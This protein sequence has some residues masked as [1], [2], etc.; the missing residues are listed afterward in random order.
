MTREKYPRE[1]LADLFAIDIRSLALFRIVLSSVILLDLALRVPLFD[2]LTTAQGVL[3]RPPF[4]PSLYWFSPQFVAEEVFFALG[5]A[6]T[7]SLLVGFKTRFFGILSW[8]SLLSL[9][10][11]NPRIVDSAD[12]V[13]IQLHFWGLL[14]PWGECFSVDAHIKGSRKIDPAVKCPA[15]VLSIAS[16]GLLLQPAFVYFFSVFHKIKGAAWR[17]GTAVLDALTYETRSRPFGLWIADHDWVGRP[18]T[19]VTLL[20]ELVAPLLLF[21][22]WRTG[23]TRLVGI[24]CLLVFQLALS[25]SLRLGLFPLVMSIALVPF[26][27]EK[28][29][30]QPWVHAWPLQAC[31]RQLSEGVRQT[32][33]VP[34][35]FG[36][37]LLSAVLLSNVDHLTS[38]ITLAPL[39]QTPLTW[40]RLNQNWKMFAPFPPRKNEIVRA[41][42]RLSDGT[43][44]TLDGEGPDRFEPLAKIRNGYRGEIYFERLGRWMEASEREDFAAWLVKQWVAHDAPGRTVSNVELSRFEWSRDAPERREETVLL[45]WRPPVNQ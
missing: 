10:V 13:L 30:N 18:L 37:T 25:L 45:N 42:L 31:S 16:A 19:Y 35:F 24:L 34:Q 4:V 41:T 28:F 14:L 8:V 23:R 2:E 6:C 12:S 20:I 43:T 11:R 7:L 26:V 5:A 27:P 29:W 15:K 3:S 17:D 9:Q 36:V 21:S 38:R 22:T 39:V 40:L 33:L 44:V 32:S 1:R